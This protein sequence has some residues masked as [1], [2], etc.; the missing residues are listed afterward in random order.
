M[1]VIIKHNKMKINLFTLIF[2]F[3]YSLTGNAQITVI[4]SF[5]PGATTTLCGIGYDPDSAQVWVYG[6]S[7]NTVLC[8]DTVGNLLN[9]IP[10]PG[11]TANDV[12][13]EIAPVQ[14]LMNGN[15]I[16]K[17]QLL[18]VNGEVD[19]AEIY[20]VNNV[21]GTIFDTL[22]TSFGTDHVVGGAYHPQ[23]NTFF[24]LQDNVPGAATE[25][26]IAEINPLT[27]DTLQTFQITN[28]MSVFFGDIDVGANGNLLVVSSNKDSIAEFSP[29]GSFVQMHDLPAGVTQLSGLGLDNATGQAWV[30]SEAAGIVFQLGN[31]PGG[32]TS[33]AETAQQQ[34][35]LS[36]ATPNPFSTEINFSIMLE[37]PGK[38]K[39]TLTNMLGE[40]VKAIYDGNVEAGTK[41]FSIDNMSFTNGVYFLKAESNFITEV[42]RMIC[43]K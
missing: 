35:Y 33:V 26:L 13:I 6:C 27:G 9:T 31:F 2:I 19:A 36:D 16:P 32:T 23:R 10:V 14:L 25:N 43:I 28:Y 29:T 24:M 15:S 22:F 5:N 1:L 3:L 17:G 37:L 41:H 21:S 38:L 11:G 18:F 20:A 4:S 7:D 34:F 8:Y 30:T 40:A 39:I 42:K 12:D